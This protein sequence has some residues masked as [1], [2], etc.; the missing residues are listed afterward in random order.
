MVTWDGAFEASP[1]DVDELKYGANKIRE[2]KAAISERE[3]LEHDFKVGAQPFHKAGKCSVLYVGTT[4][5]I[6]ALT[7]MPAGSIAWDTTLTV[8]KKYSGTAWEVCQYDHGGLAGLADD[9]HPQYL[10]LDKTGQTLSQ[11]LAV[12]AGIT[13]D[14]RDV[15]VDGASLNTHKEGTAASQHAGGLGLGTIFGLWDADKVKDTIYQAATDG[16]VIGVSLSDSTGLYGYTDAATPP[17]VL[18][19]SC[20][21]LGSITMAVKKGDYWKI[22][23]WGAGVSYSLYWLPIGG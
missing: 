2:L 3:E 18:R 14:G 19:S 10:K 15:S 20:P 6:N 1:A 5:E 21:G 9:D 12:S 16:L 7:G 23:L 4:T 8:F 22:V 11:N 13:V 17:T